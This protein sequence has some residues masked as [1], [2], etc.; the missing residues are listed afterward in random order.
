MVGAVISMVK[1][2]KYHD[3]KHRKGRENWRR[4]RDRNRDVL[5][6]ARMLKVK[7]SEA[8]ALLESNP[9]L[10]KLVNSVLSDKTEQR[11]AEIRE[12]L[13]NA[14]QPLPRVTIYHGKRQVEKPKETEKE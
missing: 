5:T 11:F 6:C 12:Q 7:I 3:E 14:G 8:R 10:R 13:K 4:W 2:I 9:E 1:K